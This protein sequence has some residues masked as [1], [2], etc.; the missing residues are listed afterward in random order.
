MIRAS[1]NGA[2]FTRPSLSAIAGS[3]CAVTV[4]IALLG[5]FDERAVEASVTRVTRACPVHTD[6]AVGAVRR[7][8]LEATVLTDEARLTKAGSV[9]AVAV[10]R[11]VIRATTHGAIVTGE[12]GVTNT[13][14]ID[15]TSVI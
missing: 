15:T 2:I 12:V 7:A 9:V 8:G 3:I 11:A 5:T 10:T 6:T 1:G 14:E 4:T 13:C